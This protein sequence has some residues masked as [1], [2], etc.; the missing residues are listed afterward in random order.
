[1]G[2]KAGT[3][4]GK[5][6]RPSAAGGLGIEEMARA[7]LGLA[8]EATRNHWRAAGHVC[9]W[10]LRLRGRG[11]Q[12]PWA[13]GPRAAARAAT[14]HRGFRV[15]TVIQCTGMW[16]RVVCL[17][18]L[19]LTGPG[20]SAVA[21]D[22]LAIRRAV[23]DFLRVQIKGLPGNASYSVGNVDAERLA[24]TC[25]GYEVSMANGG[26]PWGRTQV[27][28]R[29]RGGTWN[30][31]VPVQIRVVAEYLVAARPINAGQRL[32]EADFRRQIGELSE[33]PNGILMDKE[34]AIGRTTIASLAP[35]R[36]LRSDMLRQATVV[37]QGQ[38]VKIVGSGSGF[39]VANEG[40]ALNSAVVGQVA[41]V[42]LNSGQV[43]SGI[44]KADGTIEIK[45]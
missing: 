24:G 15:E 31:W 30:L 39:Q 42:R 8:V 5:T 12:Q 7:S 25:E 23:E 17:A 45:F 26:R 2:G 40:R 21:A 36:P 14:S 11:R 10:G 3:P 16:C 43:L 33:L 34:Q 20:Q 19:L 9:K 1:M 35:G 6:C 27:A 41:Q 29:C 37:Q 18:F 22:S 13:K 28:V 32:V 38:S 44:A 4:I